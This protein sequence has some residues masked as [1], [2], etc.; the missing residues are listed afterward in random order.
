MWSLVTTGVCDAGFL[1]GGTG[2]IVCTGAAE[3]LKDVDKEGDLP[4]AL[5]KQLSCGHC[6]KTGSTHYGAEWE[7]Y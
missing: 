2:G 5:D 7:E 1:L 3:I 6:A 4:A